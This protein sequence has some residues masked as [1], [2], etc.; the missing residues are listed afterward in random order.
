MD[1]AIIIR[2]TTGRK[3]GI[4]VKMKP[5]KSEMIILVMLFITLWGCIL[6]PYIKY[7]WGVGKKHPA[8]FSIIV[9]KNMRN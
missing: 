2:G 4:G 5:T 3:K 1:G 9:A 7:G 6:L 8:P